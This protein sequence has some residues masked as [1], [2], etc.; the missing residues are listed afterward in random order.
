MNKLTFQTFE[1]LNNVIQDLTSLVI[2]LISILI[3]HEDVEYNE[4]KDAIEKFNEIQS[5]KY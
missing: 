3:Q 4:I 5:I 1:I 2:E